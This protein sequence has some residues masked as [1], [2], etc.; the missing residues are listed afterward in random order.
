MLVATVIPLAA[1]V[2][3][4]SRP[5]STGCRAGSADRRTRN[6]TVVHGCI[7]GPRPRSSWFPG[8]RRFCPWSRTATAC[9]CSTA[10][11][12]NC[13]AD[14]RDGPWHGGRADQGLQGRTELV[15]ESGRRRDSGPEGCFRARCRDP[16]RSVHVQVDGETGMDDSCPRI[17]VGK[18]D[19]GLE[20]EMRLAWVLVFPADDPRSAL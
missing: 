12:Q 18:A 4:R 2:G 9:P 19:I 17:E 11:G 6:G 15:A 20:V 8:P 13:S 5:S 10:A 3:S 1:H 14:G 16:A 7:P